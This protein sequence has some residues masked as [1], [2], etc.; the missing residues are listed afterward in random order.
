[1]LR[2]KYI[3]AY[4]FSS[5]FHSRHHCLRERAHPPWSISHSSSPSHLLIS[6]SPL[7]F[8]L[9][10]RTFD[11]GEKVT[12]PQPWAISPHFTGAMVH[13]RKGSYCHGASSCWRCVV[14]PRG[15]GDDVRSCRVSS[16]SI[17]DLHR[18]QPWT[19]AGVGHVTGELRRVTGDVVYTVGVWD[20]LPWS[21][22]C[23]VYHDL[24]IQARVS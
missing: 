6:S 15:G 21:K 7:L 17:V 12:H 16:P 18:H 10:F 9:W 8:F 13:H 23:H 5:S 22:P 24:M 11:V 20:P 4:I 1:V 3:L 14:E 2:P 19:S